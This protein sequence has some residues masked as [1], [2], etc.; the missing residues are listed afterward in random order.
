[1]GS[2]SQHEADSDEGRGRP[3]LIRLLRYARPYVTLML[4]TFALSGL[5]SIGSYARAYLIKPVLDNVVV[6]SQSLGGAAS[7]WLP[8]LGLSGSG[9][10]TQAP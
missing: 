7:G 2:I 5:F 4:V 1:L 3:V 8:D 9:A 10:Q 6:P